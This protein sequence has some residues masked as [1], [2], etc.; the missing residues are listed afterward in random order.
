[1]SKSKKPP[2]YPLR[3]GV[4]IKMAEDVVKAA[5]FSF[6]YTGIKPNYRTA[7]GITV[8]T[9]NGPLEHHATFW[10][11]S[12]ESILERLEDAFTGDDICRQMMYADGIWPGDPVPEGYEMPQPGPPRAVVVAFDSPGGEAAGATWA[13]RRIQKL[14]KKYDIPLFAFAREMACSAAYELASACDEIW[15]P[16]T[17]QVGSIGVIATLFDRTGANEKAGLVVELITSGE[18]KSDN[19]A[20]RPID[21]GVRE[22]IT[23]RVMQ[24]A[25]I[26]WNVV[27]KS[28]G[29]SPEAVKALQ[30]GVFVGQDAV[31][32]GIADGVAEWNRFLGIVKNATEENLLSAEPQSGAA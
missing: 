14:R 3:R 15:L 26:F 29:T 19:H 21:D 17:G 25:D 1:M 9:V 13:H 24:L 20:D 18:Y 7:S 23:Y 10:W 11:D 5:D 31:D 4:P 32:V 2:A 16:D 8:V 22:R 6:L 30:A 12:Y 27:A 28:R